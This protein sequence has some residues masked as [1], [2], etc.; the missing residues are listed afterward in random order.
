[1]TVSRLLSILVRVSGEPIPI[2]VHWLWRPP[3]AKGLVH[4]IWAKLAAEVTSSPV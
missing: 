3:L 2:S 4:E 1:M